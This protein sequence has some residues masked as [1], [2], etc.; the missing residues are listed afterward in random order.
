MATLSLGSA[1]VMTFTPH[2]ETDKIGADGKQA[3]PLISLLLEP[4][5][6]IIFA[7]DAYHTHL[8]CIHDD[9]VD[10]LGAPHHGEFVN[11]GD[12]H[13]LG[14]EIL[15]TTRQSLTLRRRRVPAPRR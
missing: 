6:L 10:V 11:L 12:T 3:N 5:S 1:A 14:D 7:D 15:R 2:V 9:A 13:S 8:H 4:R